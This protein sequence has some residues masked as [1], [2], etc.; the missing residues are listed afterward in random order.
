MIYTITLNPAIDH[1]ILSNKPVELGITNIYSDEYKVIGGKGI[2]AGVILNNLE[3]KV[4][5]IGIMGKENKDIFL[6]KFQEVRLNN[7][8]LLNPGNTRVNYK[9]KHLESHQETELNGMGFETESKIIDELLKYLELNLEKKDIVIVTGS[10]ARGISKDIYK[11]IGQI[12]NKKEALLV[13]DAN[14]ELLKNA[15]EAKPYLIKPNLEEIYSTLGLEFE[16]NISFEKE[17]E[18]IEKLQN[19]GAQNVLLSKGSKGSLY[20]TSDKKIYQ[21]GIAKGKLVNSVGAGDSM[22]AGFV[23]GID[24]NLSVEKTLQYAAASGGATAFNEWLASKEEILALI[25]QIEVVV[26]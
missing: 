12:V 11:T 5:A 25:D 24:N 19:L 23:Y 15:L 13:C 9:I 20:F 22:L 21:V 18:L 1:I 16:E 2:N 4:K 3:S 17:K 26:K 10:V 8:F 6:N 7:H 14:N